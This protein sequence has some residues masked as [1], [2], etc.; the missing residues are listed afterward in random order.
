LAYL[1]FG[2]IGKDLRGFSPQD[3][4]N[5]QDDVTTHNNVTNL[6]TS[7]NKKVAFTLAEVLITL[8]II[9]VVAAITMPTLIKNYQKQ[10]YV[11]QL[12]KTY[13]TLSQGFQKYLADNGTDNFKNTELV[14]SGSGRFE[15]KTYTYTSIYPQKIDDLMKNY[16]KVVKT[17]YIETCDYSNY[18]RFNNSSLQEFF[19][20]GGEGFDD[21]MS[22]YLADGTI[23]QIL[24]GFPTYINV[25]T[26]GEK[27]PNKFG[28]DLFRFILD[29]NK[30]RPATTSDFNNKAGIQCKDGELRQVCAEKIMQDGWKM[31]Y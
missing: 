22:Y 6:F 11:A 2:K 4:V 31:N 15:G 24:F 27:G 3:D 13:T 8:G 19:G 12:K 10:V 18:E 21:Y 1:K 29:E 28:R 20:T 17:C 5:S 7:I 23:V 30:F 9:G 26:N 16:F 25:D 14:Y